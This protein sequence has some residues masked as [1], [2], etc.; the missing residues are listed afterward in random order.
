MDYINYFKRLSN[1]FGIVDWNEI[2]KSDIV[3]VRHDNDCSCLID[4]KSYSHL[5]DSI[6]DEVHGKIVTSIAAPF[7]TEIKSKSYSN[8]LSFNGAFAREALV[9]RL[10]RIFN[11]NY[12]FRE[13]A[14]TRTWRKI[15]M[16]ARPKLVLAI[17]PSS[18]LCRVCHELGIRVFDIQHGFIGDNN[19][20]Y[21]Y[22][23]QMSRSRECLPDCILCWD[24]SSADSLQKWTIEKGIEVRIIGNP[25]LQ[26][27]MINRTDDPIV[28]YFG[29][30]NRS[31]LGQKGK[32]RILVALQWGL[33]DV[34]VTPNQELFTNEFMPKALEEAIKQTS[35]LYEWVLRPHPVQYKDEKVFQR[36]VKYVADRFGRNAMISRCV[37]LPLVLSSADLLITYSSSAV[38]EADFLGV[39]SALLDPQLNGGIVGGYF[40]QQIKNGSASILHCDAESI[41]SWVNASLC[42]SSWKQ[43]N[44]DNSVKIEYF[45]F[46]RELQDL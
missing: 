20:N 12:E 40:E 24:N 42:N 18:S 34:A 41:M 22:S 6:V 8:A 10:W 43:K 29:L 39:K 44:I 45:A 46:L 26:K 35:D 13:F 36:L 21:G 5:L 27:F 15:L 4:G 16:A 9:K 19:P 25:W 31:E 30:L 28:K 11:R 32:P 14:H 33:Y 23:F 38:I 37:P 3:L 7:S 2:P 1:I 17:E